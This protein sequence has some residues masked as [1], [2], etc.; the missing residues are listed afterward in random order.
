MKFE[1]DEDKN[2]EN[3]KKHNVSFETAQKAFRDVNRM[4]TKDTKHS[5]KE[6]RLFGIGNDG[7]GILTVRFT[8]RNETIRIIGAG[9]WRGGKVK[10]EQKN[11]NLY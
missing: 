9:Y 5:K 11:S 6:E 2:R 8:V 10:Y 3:I 4:I 7:Y 1:W